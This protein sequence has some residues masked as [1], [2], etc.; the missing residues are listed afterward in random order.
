[1]KRSGPEIFLETFPAICEEC[2][3]RQEELDLEKG[4]NFLSTKIWIEMPSPSTLS[5]LS[6]FGG[7]SRS[8]PA[9]ALTVNVDD[10]VHVIKLKIMQA[11]N[12]QPAAQQL[13]FRGQ[14]LQNAKSVFDYRLVSG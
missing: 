4:M 2:T 10:T 3:R 12:I 7:A 13:W 11:M 8:P 14:I 5:T 9:F 6:S 1:M